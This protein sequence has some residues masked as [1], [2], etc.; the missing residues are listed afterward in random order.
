MQSTSSAAPPSGAK[1]LISLYR[2]GAE[3]DVAE[4]EALV[5][6]LQEDGADWAD[7]GPRLREV[8][9]NVKGQGSA[10]GY[11]LMTRV[12]ESLSKLIHATEAAD[13]RTTKL[14]VAHV[15]TLRTVL[16]RD[17][18]G[19]GGELGNHLASKLE[20]LVAKIAEH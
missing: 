19:S 2:E 10:F 16:E 8:V 20:S 5:A 18:T 14:L 6:R 13:T 9:H 15:T 17:I 4:L 12:G 7:C 1:D 3:H 11:E